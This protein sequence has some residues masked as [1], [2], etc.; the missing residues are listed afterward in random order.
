MAISDLISLETVGPIVFISLF[1]VIGGAALGIT[2]RGWVNNPTRENLF[3]R[4][5]FLIWGGMFGCMPLVF[6]IENGTLL[7][8][9]VVLL[10]AI[11]VPF[12]WLEH[13]REMFSDQNVVMVKE[14]LAKF[15]PLPVLKK[16]GKRYT[17]DY[18]RPESIGK[19]RDFYGNA[20]VILRVYSWIMSLGTEGLN[21]VAEVAV[22]NNNYLEKLL[23]AIPGIGPTK[24]GLWGEDRSEC[25]DY[26]NFSGALP[27]GKA[28]ALCQ[29]KF[30]DDFDPAAQTMR[31]SPS[32]LGT[33]T[34]S[35]RRPSA[36]WRF[37]PWLQLGVL[38]KPR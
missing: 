5:F 26:L 17:L 12:M 27:E 11:A 16:D 4:V 9:I 13:L 29:V 21:E 35:P 25:I 18:D 6:G 20:Q 3:R 33:G 36:S 1:H 32:G 31:N 2:L 23:L 22:L 37:S 15:L 34:S 19:V 7:V 8:Q 10:V 14:H 30:N 24:L 28:P 38:K